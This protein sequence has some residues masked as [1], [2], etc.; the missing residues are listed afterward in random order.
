M[1]KYDGKKQ[2]WLHLALLLVA[3]LIAAFFILQFI[4]GI[5][6]VS[7]SSMEPNYRDGNIVVYYRI[8]SSYNRGDIVSLSMP[9][10][11]RYLKRVVG[12]P[13][14]VIDIS[15]GKLFINGVAEDGAYPHTFTETQSSTVEYPY[16]VEPGRY[17]VVG[18]NREVSLDSRTFAT[19][20]AKQIM[21][22]VVFCLG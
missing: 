2:E 15:D 20:T 9:S 3:M 18:D 12:V 14:D 1:G 22:T 17:F 10:G 7:G 21:G 4:F 5:S 11:E 8:Q 19:V 16:T 13:G 6:T